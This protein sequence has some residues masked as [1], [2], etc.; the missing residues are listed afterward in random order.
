MQSIGQLCN[1]TLQRNHLSF[2]V[3]KPQKLCGHLG[4]Q[5]LV[6]LHC[7]VRFQR[8]N[9]LSECLGIQSLLPRI[10]LALRLRDLR[11]IH[12]DS[13]NGPFLALDPLWTPSRCTTRTSQFFD[14]SMHQNVFF[15]EIC[16]HQPDLL[17]QLSIHRLG[18]L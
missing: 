18:L 13:G 16:L 5:K 6:L 2:Q 4:I 17:F 1:L 3:V 7:H 15:L 10:I 9:L 8:L 12:V 14:K 11:A